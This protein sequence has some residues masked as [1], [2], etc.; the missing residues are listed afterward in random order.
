MLQLN[1]IWLSSFRLHRST[2]YLDIACCYRLNSVVCLSVGLS[3]MVVSPAKMA[4]PIEMPCGLGTRL[5]PRNH[6][7]DG[8]LDLS[9]GRGNFRGRGG[10]L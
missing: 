10:P 8:G 6:V 4:E 1:G 9:M 2:T 5:G 3:V 7:L